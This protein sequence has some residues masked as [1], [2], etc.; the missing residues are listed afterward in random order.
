MKS[1]KEKIRDAVEEAFEKPLKKPRED[2]IKILNDLVTGIRLGIADRYPNLDID[3][4]L[5]SS[6]NCRK[7]TVEIPYRCLPDKTMLFEFL[8]FGEV[9]RITR[10]DINY[11]CENVED[12]KRI[13]L[14]VVEGEEFLEDLQYAIDMASN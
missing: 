3:V 4:V 14:D 5:Q 2:M 9:V 13:L 10:G 8:F 12:F 1:F 7:M 11:D 6:D